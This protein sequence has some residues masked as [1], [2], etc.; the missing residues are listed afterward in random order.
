MY[1]KKQTAIIGLIFFLVISLGGSLINALLY[2]VKYKERAFPSSIPITDNFDSEPVIDSEPVVIT[3]WITDES[4]NVS[5]FA[6]ESSGVSDG[7]QAVRENQDAIQGMEL[8]AKVLS[9]S[10]MNLDSFEK[11]TKGKEKIKNCLDWV[12]FKRGITKSLINM[13]RYRVT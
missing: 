6:S 5:L 12:C 1:T 7:G 4:K 2:N 3:I 8:S 11:I 9:W 13:Q 10:Y